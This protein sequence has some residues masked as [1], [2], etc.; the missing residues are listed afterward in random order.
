MQA[1]LALAE[2][3][4]KS[5]ADSPQAKALRD[6]RGQLNSNPDIIKTLDEYRQ[7][8]DKVGKLEQENK[9][10]E[11]ADKQKLQQLQGQLVSD[12]V[13]KTFT[14]AQVE[15]VDIMRQVNETLRKEL[16]STEQD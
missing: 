12:E 16:A 6:A 14:A 2:R 1:I 9:P 3:L 10:I 13:F 15:Y 11:V 7:Q 4:G 5:I 8:A